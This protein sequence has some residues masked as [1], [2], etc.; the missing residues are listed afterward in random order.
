MN[1]WPF[2]STNFNPKDRHS[3]VQE[4]TSEAGPEVTVMLAHPCASE[5]TR[6]RTTYVAALILRLASCGP[7][8]SSISFGARFHHSVFPQHRAQL[9]IAQA[10]QR[11][12]LDL[13][14]A[15]FGE[16]ALDQ[17]DFETG[18]FHLEVARQLQ[19]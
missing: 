8:S 9:V 18:D 10:Q 12:G 6:L 3:I 7:I 4:V 15:G 2:H 14:V 16:R 11:R 17:F 1:E 5:P 19:W 13:V